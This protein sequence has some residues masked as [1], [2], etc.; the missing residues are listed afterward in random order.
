[1][2]QRTDLQTTIM[3]ERIERGVRIVEEEAKKYGLK[4]NET[5][6]VKGCEIGISL[7]IQKERNRT[8]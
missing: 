4:M 5:L 1:M 6:F 3:Q 7:F 2:E 8:Q